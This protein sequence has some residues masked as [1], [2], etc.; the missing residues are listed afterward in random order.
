[1]GIKINIRRTEIVKMQNS[2]NRCVTVG[3]TDFKRV[4][5]FTYMSCDIKKN[6][7][8]RIEVC[9]R[10]GKARS[11]FRVLSKVCNAHSVSLDTNFMLFYGI[12]TY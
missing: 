11:T 1:M 12:L 4:K 2:D 3:D 9:T 5:K 7:N 8:V 10:T 6:D